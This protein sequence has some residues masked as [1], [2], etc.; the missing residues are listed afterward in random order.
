MS[1]AAAR[2]PGGDPALS[3]LHPST[4]R[5]NPTCSPFGHRVCLSLCMCCC[6]CDEGERSASG[7]A[8]NCNYIPWDLHHQGRKVL[9]LLLT[10]RTLMRPPDRRPTRPGPARAGPSRASAPG[11]ERRCAAPLDAPWPRSFAFRSIACRAATSGRC[12][13]RTACGRLQRARRGRLVGRGAQPQ[14]P[15]IRP[16]PRTCWHSPAQQ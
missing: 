11:L 1:F 3:R 5:P 4:P 2:P 10:A 14:H 16:G 6:E 12:P 7:S 13:C 15:R 8:S 9:L